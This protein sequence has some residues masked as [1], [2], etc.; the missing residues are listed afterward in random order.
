[1]ERDTRIDDHP[2][3]LD[4]PKDHAVAE[5]HTVVLETTDEPQ[6]Q[7]IPQTRQKEHKG[8]EL[9]HRRAEDLRESHS[10]EQSDKDVLRRKRAQP[11]AGEKSMANS[12]G[13][14]KEPKEHSQK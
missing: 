9:G 7:R 4:E 14:T 2:A 11:T 10:T 1:M 5:Y 6:R 8:E 13:T 3:V 12:R